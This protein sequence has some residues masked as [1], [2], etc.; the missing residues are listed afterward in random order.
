MARLRHK[1]IKSGGGWGI[2]AYFLGEKGY[3]S[4]THGFPTMKGAEAQIKREKK[5]AKLCEQLFGM[6]INERTKKGRRKK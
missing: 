5:A 3:V 1:I 2:R 6:Q 4:E